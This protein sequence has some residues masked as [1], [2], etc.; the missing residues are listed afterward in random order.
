M[1]KEKWCA[2]TKVFAGG[3]M[4]EQRKAALSSFFPLR[5]DPYRE[6]HKADLKNLGMVRRSLSFPHYDLRLR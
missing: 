2:Q 5:Q 6:L 3:D 1:C 4:L